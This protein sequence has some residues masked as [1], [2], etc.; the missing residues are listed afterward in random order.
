MQRL[1]ALVSLA[2]P[3]ATAILA[4][5]RASLL[6]GT[7]TATDLLDESNSIPKKGQRWEGGG[8]RLERLSLSPRQAHENPRGDFSAL[9]GRSRTSVP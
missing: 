6:G 5:I 3:T 1:I 8:S 4:R 2:A 9:V 7:R